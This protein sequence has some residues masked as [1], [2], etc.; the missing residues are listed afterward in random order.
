MNSPLWGLVSWSRFM[1]EC[2]SIKLCHN[3]EHV[4]FLAKSEK[5]PPTSSVKSHSQ[6]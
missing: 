6:Q 2:C 1:S 3:N 4:D 5:I